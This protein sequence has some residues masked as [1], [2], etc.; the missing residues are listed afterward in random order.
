[1][2]SAYENS[3]K[4]TMVIKP[5]E[6]IEQIRPNYSKPV[7]YRRTEPKPL[8]KTGNRIL[9]RASRKLFNGLVLNKHERRAIFR[10]FNR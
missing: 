1:M 6:F 2:L 5:P 7:T 8:T 9:S 3:V 4:E 10:E